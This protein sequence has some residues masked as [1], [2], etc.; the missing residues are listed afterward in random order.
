[1]FNFVEADE[2]VDVALYGCRPPSVVIPVLPP[3][4]PLPPP[5]SLRPN[6]AI[7]LN[8][9]DTSFVAIAISEEDVIKG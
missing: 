1:M 6:T 7:G 3:P 2:L 8:G 4:P 9:S 5:P